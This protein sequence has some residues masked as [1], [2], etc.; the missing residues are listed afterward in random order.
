MKLIFIRHAEPDYSI[1]SL[2]EKGWKEAELLAKRTAKWDVKDFYCSPLGRAKDTASFTLKHFGREAKIYD[3]LQEF[4]Y[5]VE[6]P[7]TGKERVGWDFYPRYF[8][9]ERLMYD[10]DKWVE[11]PIYKNSD[12]PAK[13][14]EVK[15]G[16]DKILLE[17]GYRRNGR[18]Y[19]VEQG[20][21]DTLVF[22]CHLGVQFVMLSH[23]LG[24]PAPLLW[25]GVFVAP[26]SVTILSTEERVKGEAYFRLKCIGDTSHLYVADE[27]PSDSGFFMET[28]HEGGK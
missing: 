9:K 14:E 11:S 24:I 12:M 5:R 7:Y 28:Y 4:Y 1:D 6:D 2:T 3:W 20:N 16:L 21:E 17:H 23:L 26:S 27:P 25:Q 8:T 15:S 10:P 19:S 22:F 18:F 13:Y